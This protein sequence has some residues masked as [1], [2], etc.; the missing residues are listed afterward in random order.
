MRILFYKA[1][2]PR[3]WKIDW[4]IAKWTR[5]PYSHAELQFS[6]GVCFSSSKRDGGT[7]FKKIRVNPDCWDIIELNDITFE[8]E[9][10]IFDWCTAQCG[11]KYDMLGLFGFTFKSRWINI[12]ARDKW[13]CSE[14]VAA[15][16]REN[17]NYCTDLF[18]KI[19][20]NKL[21]KQMVPRAG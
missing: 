7:R 16:L 13:Y 14:I 8:Q 9:K 12:H 11:K 17:I 10:E 4:I 21:Y 19:S 6:H 15:A 3:A 5:G 1:K 2:Q 18:K 20:P